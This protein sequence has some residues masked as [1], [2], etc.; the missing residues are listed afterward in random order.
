MD[1]IWSISIDIDSKILDNG[2]VS[3]LHIYAP[4]P[5]QPPICTSYRLG[6]DGLHFENTYFLYQD[7]ADHRS[8]AMDWLKTS[9]HGAGH[10]DLLDETWFPLDHVA[11]AH[12]PKRDGFYLG[13]LR[14]TQAA[15]FLRRVGSPQWAVQLIDDP[16]GGYDHLLIEVAADLQR[17]SDGASRVVRSAF[18]GVV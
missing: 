6:L 7:C 11:L 12:K 2:E 3:G 10:H 14:S 13:A 4:H 1:S 8:A 9:F 17:M 18:H 16:N 5:T 15:D